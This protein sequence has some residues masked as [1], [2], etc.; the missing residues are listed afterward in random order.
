MSE[1]VC[2]LLDI[3]YDCDSVEETLVVPDPQDTPISSM[4]LAL[5]P[6]TNSTPS[7]A[8]NLR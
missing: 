5:V 6:L 3:R 7:G 1:V 8:G 4:N 2:V